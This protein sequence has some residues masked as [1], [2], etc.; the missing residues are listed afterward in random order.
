MAR[1]CASG[2]PTTT[3]TSPK[4]PHR[5]FR[6]LSRSSGWNRLEAAHDNLRAALSWYT[7]DDSGAEAELQLAEALGWFLIIQGYLFEGRDWLRRAGAQQ[8]VWY[9]RTR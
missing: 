3:A 5:A 4:R 9:E 7:Q 1:A 6:A 2:T 8:G